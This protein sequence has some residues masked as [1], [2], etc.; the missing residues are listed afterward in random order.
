[1]SRIILAILEFWT[2]RFRWTSWPIRILGYM[3]LFIPAF[4]LSRKGLR[5]DRLIRDRG[6]PV[7]SQ[8]AIL[9]TYMGINLFHRPF[10]ESGPLLIVCNHPG[11]GDAH[12]VMSMLDRRDARLIVN[13]SPIYRSL[14]RFRRYLLVM[15]DDKRAT[16]GVIRSILE[17][18][19]KGQ[20]VVLFPAGVVEP[21]PAF[22]AP[23]EDF[24]RDWSPLV[25][26]LCR[27]AAKQSFEFSV[28]PVVVS[29]T[30]SR[31][32]FYSYF[33]RK[34]TRLEKRINV[35]MVSVLIAGTNRRQRVDVMVGD[36]IPTSR[37]LGTVEHPV[38][39]TEFVKER[40]RELRRL[41]LDIPPEKLRSVDRR[42][43][44]KLV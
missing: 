7:G 4:L 9:M 2:S 15:P 34:Q 3:I 21:E 10:P 19:K 13:D 16:V 18:L 14:V 8:W 31:R 40:L 25:G 6:L 33:I 22:C 42:S 12:S 17:A 20:A 11:L 37:I 32:L 29:G 26:F 30:Y 24:L 23:N 43:L 44:W 27:Q 41:Q 1:M 5:Y 38:E 35:A 36:P 39:I 28:V